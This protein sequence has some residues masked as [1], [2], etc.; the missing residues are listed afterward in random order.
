MYIYPDIFSEQRKN[1]YTGETDNINTQKIFDSKMFY[2]DFTEFNSYVA[3]YLKI[4]KL[5]LLWSVDTFMLMI[6]LDRT[7]SSVVIS[8]K[9]FIR[10]LK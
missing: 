7:D 5:F 1:C 4:P 10:M 6:D 2:F 3:N 8:L 9:L